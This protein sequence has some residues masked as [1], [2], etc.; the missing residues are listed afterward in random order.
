MSPFVTL[1]VPLGALWYVSI[2]CSLRQIQ[3]AMIQRE[4][5]DE[6]LKLPAEERR[7]KRGP[8]EIC[9]EFAMHLFPHV[10]K[11]GP[12]PKAS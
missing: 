5:I 6:L 3:I 8:S 2:K 12:V 9:N 4:K 7:R 1:F 11:R 10:G